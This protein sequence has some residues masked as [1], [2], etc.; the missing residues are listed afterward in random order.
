[1][2]KD[3][4]RGLLKGVGVAIIV[5]A[6]IF[7]SLI[8]NYRSEMNQNTLSAEEIESIARDNGMVYITEVSDIET[9]SRE[10]IIDRAK[11]YGMTFD[12]E[13]E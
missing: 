5:C 10:Y 8:L 4:T 3:E 7:Y 11:A 13:S 1:M 2:N 9:L 12:E 6:T